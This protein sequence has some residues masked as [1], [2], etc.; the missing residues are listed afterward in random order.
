MDRRE[1]DVDADERTALGQLLDYHRA[2]LLGKTEGL[3]AAGLASRLPSSTLTL[4]G[5]LKHLALNEDSWFT[6]RFAGS[7]ALPPWDA[8]DWD[9]DPDWEFRTAADDE[10]DALRSLYEAACERSRAAVAA[11]DDLSALSA[12]TDSEG[13]RWSLR[14][15]LLHMLEETARHNGHADLL[16]EAV[17]GTTGE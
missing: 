11:A 10:P 3:D 17:D 4:G 14:A 13:R 9:A 15:I 16:R 2:T 1:P 12:W 7:P 5:L 6:E 8:V